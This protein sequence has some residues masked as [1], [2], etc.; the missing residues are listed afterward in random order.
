MRTT[1]KTLIAVGAVALL[2][3]NSAI[4]AGGKVNFTTESTGTYDQVVQNSQG[5]G[6]GESNGTTELKFQG[7]PT[8]N[9]YAECKYTIS[10]SLPKDV[11]GFCR[12]ANQV[13]T[14]SFITVFECS[15]GAPPSPAIP[16]PTRKCKGTVSGGTGL[17][18]NA[19][20]SV[21]WELVPVDWAVG[22]TWTST[23][24]KGQGTITY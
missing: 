9:M 6:V 2:S 22:S 19:A 13:N 3:S 15:S 8:F 20:G 21:K 12:T 18:Q 14:D 10:P 7:G 5:Y 17:F 23:T 1:F 11:E 4:A 16:I 24:G